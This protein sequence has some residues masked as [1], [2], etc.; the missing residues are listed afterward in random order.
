MKKKLIRALAGNL[1]TLALVIGD[2]YYTKPDPRVLIFAFIMTC[3]LRYI[4]IELLY[5]LYKWIPS[6]SFH[7]ALTA[8]VQPFPEDKYRKSAAGLPNALAYIILIL[9]LSLFPF[10]FMYLEKGEFVFSL[11]VF[12]H[13]IK[14]GLVIAMIYGLKDMLFK[15]FYMDYSQ[16]KGLNFYYNSNYLFVLWALA[17]VGG[18]LLPAGEAIGTPWL[19]VG[20]LL[21]AKHLMDLL[22]DIFWAKKSSSS[23]VESRH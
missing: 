6:E 3:M 11:S 15:G 20:I 5:Y 2:F 8:L 14:A 4:L 7:S 17:F 16:S 22:S 21:A 10:I 9:L 12:I 13:Q 19:L 18:W 1:L 23:G